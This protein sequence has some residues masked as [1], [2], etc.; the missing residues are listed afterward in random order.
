MN[1]MTTTL[2][3]AKEMDEN[4]PLQRFRNEFLI[5][6]KENKPM[7]YFCG[8]SLG[9]QPK[10]VRSQICEELD[11]WEDHGVEGHFLPAQPWITYHEELK[12]NMSAI[13]GA[14]PGEIAIM[15]TL[16]V[17]I[18][19][20]LVSFYNPTAKRFKILC[21]HGTFPSDLYAMMSQA[22]FRGLDPEDV[23]IEL[24]CRDG[25][26]TL[27]TEDILQ[28]IRDNGNDLALVFFG[29]VN[30]YTGQAFDIK[31]ITAEAHSVGAT[32]GFD[33]AHAAGNI[34]LS[35]HDDNVDFAVWCTYK[36]LNSGP[37]GISSVFIHERH[38]GRTD[39]NRFTGWWGNHL[40]TRFKMNREFEPAE[41]ADAWQLST[42]PIML[43]APLKS[44]LEIFMEA[45]FEN[46][47]VKRK[48]LTCLLEKIINGLAL[49]YSD[50]IPIHIITP[51][52]ED[53]R[54]AQLSLV[55]KRNGRAIFEQLAANG[56]I[57]DWREPEVIRV[58]PVPLYNTFEE[59]F[60]FG[61]IFDKVLQKE[62]EKIYADVT[63]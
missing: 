37:G 50:S 44:S 14:Q 59:V 63:I 15:N 21:E 61:K 36:Y 23:I 10:R 34:S 54:G 5:P 32:A 47:L 22:R 38:S 2:E 52:D 9:L 39:M 48:K 8:N 30:Y 53:D 1:D 55:F 40:P 24:R 19:L 20:M 17:N 57:A 25:E 56:I 4:D 35:L 16:T 42:S 6:Q 27:R 13:V 62:T 58:A 18:H 29:G 7:I 49:K 43:M 41:G 31:A 12:K 11:K 51:V 26:H 3:Q 28:A 60:M 33:L 46:M 45:G